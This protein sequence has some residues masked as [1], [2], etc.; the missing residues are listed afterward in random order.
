MNFKIYSHPESDSLVALCHGLAYAFSLE[1][2][3]KFGYGD[4][5]HQKAFSIGLQICKN[6]DAYFGVEAEAVEEIIGNLIIS[7]YLPS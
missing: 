4:N 1:T 5:L 7:C 2:V 3:D 6:A